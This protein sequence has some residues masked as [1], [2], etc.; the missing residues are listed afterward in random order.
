M[1]ALYPYKYNHVKHFFLYSMFN[2]RLKLANTDSYLP[3]Y[4]RYWGVGSSV[5]QDMG[6]PKN[7]P[8]PLFLSLFALKQP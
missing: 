4:G 7:P 5:P 3:I 6:T 2:V 1:R 8:Q